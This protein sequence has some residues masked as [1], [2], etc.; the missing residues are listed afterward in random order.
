[1]EWLNYSNSSG[2]AS[3]VVVYPA[4]LSKEQLRRLG[5]INNERVPQTEAEELDAILEEGLEDEETIEVAMAD[6]IPGGQSLT[7]LQTMTEILDK[8]VIPDLINKN[9]WSEMKKGDLILQYLKM[10]RLEKWS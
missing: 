1:M 5:N 7:D 6:P 4:R 9:Q 2:Y 3:Y 8:I 10:N